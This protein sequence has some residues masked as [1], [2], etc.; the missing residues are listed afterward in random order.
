MKSPAQRFRA[1]RQRHPLVDRYFSDADF[2]ARVSLYVS[3][4]INLGYSLFT[5]IA[6]ILYSSV[7]WGALSGYYLLLSLMRF[8]LLRGLKTSA[9]PYRRCLVCSVL[10]LALDVALSVVVTLMVLQSKSATYPGVLIYAVAAYTFY[11]ISV[12]LIDA[13]RYRKSREPLLIT[14]KAIR[15]A[16]ALVSLFSLEAALLTRFGEDDRF[17]FLMLC[18]SGAALCLVE[19]WMAI[20]L[21][22]RWIKE[23]KRLYLTE[24][25]RSTRPMEEKKENGGFS[26]TYSAREQTEIKHIVEKYL[27]KEDDKMEQ[28]RAL[29]RSVEQKATAASLIVGI[30]GALLFGL[31]MSCVLV[32]QL[33]IPGLLFG[34]VGLVGMAL[35]YPAYTRTL[36]KERKRVAPEILRLTR[37]LTK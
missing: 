23:P 1:F 34:L 31:G 37:E 24:P 10:M 30:G 9:P 16:A 33:L 26:Y 18:I 17:R 3:L 22:I 20:H 11:H 36:E 27:P 4:G 29:D 2:N 7:W 32:W 35:A 21:L 15:L 19:L 8:L 28:L 13:A 5:V 25:Q 14:S 12:S 6:G